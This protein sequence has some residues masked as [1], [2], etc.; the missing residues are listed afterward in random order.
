MARLLHKPRIIQRDYSPKTCSVHLLKRKTYI[1]SSLYSPVPVIAAMPNKDTDVEGDLLARKRISLAVRHTL[2]GTWTTEDYSK[3]VQ[4]CQRCRKRKIKC[5]PSGIAGD[6]QACVACQAAKSNHCQYLRVRKSQRNFEIYPPAD[7]IKV[8]SGEVYC[9]APETPS[10]PWHFSLPASEETSFSMIPSHDLSQYSINNP[11]QMALSTGRGPHRVANNADALG[12]SSSFSYNAST[13]NPLQA[14]PQQ[15]PLS[16]DFYATY[17]S[18]QGLS[19]TNNAISPTNFTL[20][21]LSP[22]WTP[23]SGCDGGTADS[24]F[25]QSNAMDYGSFQYPD[26]GYIGAEVTSMRTEGSPYF[27]GLSPLATHLPA[28]GS[29]NGKARCLPVPVQSYLPNSRG[30]SQTSESSFNTANTHFTPENDSDTWTSATFLSDHNSGSVASSG[31]TENNSPPTMRDASAYDYTH[32]LGSKSLGPGNVASLL[33]LTLPTI[34][35]TA[36]PRNQESSSNIETYTS[37]NARLPTLDPPFQEY[38]FPAAGLG[39]FPTTDTRPPDQTT[40]RTHRLLQP[41]PL[42]TL[43]NRALLGSSND[44]SGSKDGRKSAAVRRQERK[45]AGRHQ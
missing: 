16:A 10:G 31:G 44:A 23:S 35:N 11:S 6:G 7:T 41:H 9:P 32:S 42:H 25:S 14:L 43:Q 34:H 13:Q 5:E 8:N 27:P 33:P 24:G 40:P 30:P 26:S 17:Q 21:D 12:R 2:S 29:I 39:V 45:H 4:Q 38:H 15:H 1:D 19:Y 28:P 3:K 18:P 36:D 20:Q 37:H 22:P